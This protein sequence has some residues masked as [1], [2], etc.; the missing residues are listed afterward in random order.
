MS[1][2]CS[3]FFFCFCFCVFCIFLSIESYVLR[4]GK[5]STEGQ[6]HPR[7][8]NRNRRT[9]ATYA[10]RCGSRGPVEASVDVPLQLAWQVV[11][12]TRQPTLLEQ[13]EAG[14]KDQ[15]P[16]LVVG[17]GRR[18]CA[19]QAAARLW[20]HLRTA[21]AP[22]GSLAGGRGYL[23][24]RDHVGSADGA[25]LRLDRWFEGRAATS[26]PRLTHRPRLGASRL[27]LGLRLGFEP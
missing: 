11:I 9:D 27:W 22:M 3:L 7:P 16:Q 19:A 15:P 2:F 18:P 14:G 5:V 6:M 25:S 13:L 21:G 12:L 24:K 4:T 17:E 20:K 23:I 1:I 26:G 8:T 10:L